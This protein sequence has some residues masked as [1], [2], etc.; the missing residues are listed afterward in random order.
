M[1]DTDTDAVTRRTSSLL[2]ASQRLLATSA[3]IDLVGHDEA[4][5]TV[6]FEPILRF[7]MKG[8]G[9]T[10][11]EWGHGM[12]KGDEAVNFETI[13][14]SKVNA[15]DPAMIHIQAI[16]KATM[17]D[18]QGIGVLEQAIIGEHRPYGLT[19]IFDGAA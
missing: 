13:D 3:E 9:Y 14:L 12:W 18:R 8:I 11:P 7:H 5:R 15:I 2:A 4:V 19:G 16:C 10:H 6:V 17:G 1:T